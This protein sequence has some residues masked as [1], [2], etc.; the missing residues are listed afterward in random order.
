MKDRGD[1]DGAERRRYVRFTPSAPIPV[2]FE[3]MDAGADDVTGTGDSA[4]T[5]NVSGG[6][7]F[8]E[9]PRLD[10]DVLEQLLLGEKLLALEIESDDLPKPV[11]AVARVIWVEKTG[12]DTYGVGVSF[13]KIDETDRSSVTDFMIDK[14]LESD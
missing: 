12:R 9:I 10:P 7:M 14:Y 3:I 11:R 6:G 13:V 1:F 8:L 4:A 5:K 2:K